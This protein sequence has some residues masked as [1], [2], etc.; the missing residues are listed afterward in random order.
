MTVSPFVPCGWTPT[1]GVCSSGPCC[2]DT[3]DPS[4]AAQANAIATAIIYRLTGM[5]YGCCEVTVRPCKPRQCDPITLSQLIY[6]DSRAYLQFGA[7]NMGVLSFF[8]TLVGG[9]VFNISCGC[10]QGCCKCTADCEV[11]L[12]GPIC[13]ISNVTIDGITIDPS[14]YTVYDGNK[15]VFLHALVGASNYAAEIIDENE[16]GTL[17]AEDVD[18]AG[19]SSVFEPDLV[20]EAKYASV[21]P[22]CQD[23]NLSL[24]NPGT[25]SVT[26]SVGTPVPAEVNLAAG[27]YACEIGK[28]LVGDKSCGLPSNVQQVAR[29]GVSVLFQNPLLLAD[30]GLTGIPMIDTIIRTVNPNRL[31]QAPRVWYPGRTA[32][33][34]RET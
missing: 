34:R 6:W 28:L 8:P 26:Y 7:P 32:T 10:P 24:G 31:T 9:E 5:Q 33:V 30:A 4:L 21:C 3:S 25:W 20:T 11:L 1:P 2:P 16:I 12:P 19:T 22:S 29:Q 13:S 27:L 14:M 15:L 18:S 17:Q 23:Y